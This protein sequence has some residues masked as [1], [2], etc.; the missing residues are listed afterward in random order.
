MVVTEPV[1]STAGEA[2]TVVRP[3]A[4]DTVAAMAQEDIVVAVLIA[5]AAASGEEQYMAEAGSTAV[6][7]TADAGKF[8]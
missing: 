7:G 3:T 8:A 5:V 1:A 2:I 4:A 6:V